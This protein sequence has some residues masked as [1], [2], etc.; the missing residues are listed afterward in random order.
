LCGEVLLVHVGA[1]LSGLSYVMSLAF[2]YRYIYFM[3]KK[4]RPNIWRRSP[5][6]RAAF[7]DPDPTRPD[8]TVKPKGFTL[9]DPRIKTSECFQ[10]LRIECYASHTA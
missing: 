4:V 6:L 9:T 5:E 8:P 2:F 3:S 1:F 10:S 7:V